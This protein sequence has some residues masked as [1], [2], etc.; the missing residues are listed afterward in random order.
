MA[1]ITSKKILAIFL[2][3]LFSSI[4]TCFSQS[5]LYYDLNYSIEQGIVSLEGVN[6][7]GYSTGMVLE[8]KLRNLTDKE[9]RIYAFLER[10]LFLNNSGRGQDMVAISLYHYGGKYYFSSNDP[11]K[12]FLILNS[13]EEI[14]ITFLAFCLDFGKENPSSSDFFSIEKNA[15]PI[16]NLVRKIIRFAKANPEYE[17]ENAAQ[18]AIWLYSGETEYRIKKRYNYSEEDLKLAKKFLEE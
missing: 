17:F 8:G 3:I 13:N 15:Y 14:R 12:M 1:K 6:G 2:F 10:P 16:E 9:I 7:F 18:V 4:C 5:N 11:E